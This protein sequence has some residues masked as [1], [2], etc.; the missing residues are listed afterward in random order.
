[1]QSIHSIELKLN[2]PDLAA[3]PRL[4][5]KEY[6]ED[7]SEAEKAR[8]S[9]QVFLYEDNILYYR[10]A[11]I[12]TVPQLQVYQEKIRE[13]TKDM[14]SFYMLI[15][16]TK[17][18]PPSPEARYYLT[19]AFSKYKGLRHLAIFHNKNILLGVSAKFV[20]PTFGK[21][22]TVHR[23]FAQALKKTYQLKYEEESKRN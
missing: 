10:E 3:I 13:L 18:A 12:M 16:L 6:N 19:E 2:K 8:L 23:S 9:S 22:F 11:P 7:M 17:S 1:M 14:D 21:N 20:V 15:D 4:D 5:H